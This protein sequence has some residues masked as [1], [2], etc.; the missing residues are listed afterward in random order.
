MEPN[1]V[2][3]GLARPTA[4]RRPVS[5]RGRDVV[6]VRWRQNSCCVRPAITAARRPR[7]HGRRPGEGP[8]LSSPDARPAASR[9]KDL[10]GAIPKSPYVIAPAASR[11]GRSVPRRCNVNSSVEK[12]RRGDRAR[13]GLPRVEPRCVLDGGGGAADADREFFMIYVVVDDYG[14]QTR[15]GPYATMQEAEAALAQFIAKRVAA[16]IIEVE[17]ED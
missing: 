17:E 2:A 16:Q 1:W 11:Q 6:L 12:P 4:A 9:A 5:A 15:Y 14:R 7:G 3:E 10:K 13:R 8:S